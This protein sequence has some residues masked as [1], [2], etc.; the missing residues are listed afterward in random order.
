MFCENHQ[1]WEIYGMTYVVCHILNMLSESL[2]ANVEV[3][4]TLTPVELCIPM[5]M[6]YLDCFNWKQ[7]GVYTFALHYVYAKC[8][9]LIGMQ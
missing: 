8:I 6:I 5:L 1:K 9:F 4:W 3:L 7:W 2:F